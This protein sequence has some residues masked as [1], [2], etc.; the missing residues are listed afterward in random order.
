MRDVLI[1]IALSNNAPLSTAVLQSLLAFSSV[2]RHGLQSHA[3]QLKLSAISILA[4]SAKT[5]VDV[6]QVM[7]HVATLM[8]LCCFEVRET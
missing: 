1:R 5:G 7:L 2:H 6:N 3:T 4:A 8:L